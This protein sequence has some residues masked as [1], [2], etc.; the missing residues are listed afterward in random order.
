MHIK[1][2]ASS[3]RSRQL[4]LAVRLSL[5]LMLTAVLPLLLIVG[6]SEY[7]ARPIL[8][9]QANQTMETDAQTRTQLIDIYLNERLHDVETFSQVPGLWEWLTESL[10]LR[11]E[12]ATGPA[13]LEAG[14]ARDKNYATWSIFDSGAHLMLAYPQQTLTQQEVTSL[15]AWF[16]TMKVSQTGLPMISPVYYDTLIHKAFVE[17][18]SPIYQGGQPPDP[19]LGFLLVKLNLDYIWSVV[20]S[21][22]GIGNNGSSF[23][24]DQN[25][26]RIADTFKQHLFTAVAPLPSHLQQ[27]ITTEN[28][29]ETNSGPPVQANTTL[30]D[31]L[32][33]P[34]SPTHFTLTSFDQAQNYQAAF[35]KT[36]TLPWTYFVI[37]PG[38]VVT[39]VADQQL[40]TT[41]AGAFILLLLAALVG[42]LASNRI[43][44]PIMHSV[45]QLRENS[46]TLN[47]QAQRQ[48][49]TS[50][51]QSW[52]IDSS[53]V[54]L[55]SMQ[56]YTD[57]IR[58]AAHRLSEVGT[59]MRRNWHRQ[60]SAAIKQSLQ[61]IINAANYI[62]KA[63]CY[64][65]DNSQKLITAIKVTSQV[66]DQLTNSSISTTETASQLKQVVNDLRNVVGR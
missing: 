39:Q 44:R 2:N 27:Q 30:A 12:D 26:V 55:R 28:W 52:M 32:K 64:Q 33:S 38:S 36:T 53:Q 10:A 43:S 50:L 22:K 59:K 7:T 6:F 34:N 29:Y 25:G 48:Q 35:A 66:N 63:A 14:V 41:I 11:S 24:L 9:N 20:Q 18:Y 37:S 13:S 54:G 16:Q 60:D 46:E 57:A 42:M 8:I 1:E 65:S 3:R 31:I 5:T 17:I 58:I 45:V 47:K 49:S 62:E 51:E 21:D 4:P 19:F 61:E 40:L 15:P 56:Y 23:I